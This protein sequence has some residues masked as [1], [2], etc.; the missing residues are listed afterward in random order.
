MSF[1][2]GLAAATLMPL[3]SR[4]VRPFA[5]ETAAAGMAVVDGAQRLFAEQVETLQDVWAEARARYEH[6]ADE[7]IAAAAAA[8]MDHAEE[9]PAETG[10][11]RR[12]SSSGR[13]RAS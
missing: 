11:A 2:L 5:V 13:R 9:G 7:G 8:S 3:L 1:A 6:H 12:R 4:V 10:R